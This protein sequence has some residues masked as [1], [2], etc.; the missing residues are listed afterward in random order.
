[1]LVASLGVS[2]QGTLRGVPTKSR[3]HNQGEQFLPCNETFNTCH[4]V[5]HT[6][7]PQAQAW[8]FLKSDLA[9]HAGTI[10]AG[11]FNIHMILQTAALDKI[12]RRHAHDIR[13]HCAGIDLEAALV[14]ELSDDP[15]VMAA[16]V[17]LNKQVARIEADLKLLLLKL[18]TPQP[19]CITVADLLHL[20]KL[21]VGKLHGGAI[22]ITWPAAETFPPIMLDPRVL[23][24]LLCDLLFRLSEARPGE[25]LGIT[26]RE[27]GDRIRI[28]VMATMDYLP[29]PQDYL[30]EMRTMLEAGGIPVESALD[31]AGSRWTVSFDIPCADKREA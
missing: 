1:M 16:S 3:R 20:L 26:V 31:P 21:K 15:E 23:L 28:G 7:P 27:A 13:N 2:G 18:E 24:P 25:P 9:S 19:V 8:I 12:I 10:K 29:V 5:G 30:D 22:P 11:I 4:I 17:R 14:A 6:R